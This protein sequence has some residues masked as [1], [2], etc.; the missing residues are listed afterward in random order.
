[1]TRDVLLTGQVPAGH[2]TILCAVPCIGKEGKQTSLAE[3]ALQS[4]TE[5]NLRPLRAEWPFK[6]SR[7]DVDGLFVK[8]PV[9]FEIFRALKRR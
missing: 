3:Y 7:R 1:M 9:A 4:T 6:G 2:R 5:S 8:W